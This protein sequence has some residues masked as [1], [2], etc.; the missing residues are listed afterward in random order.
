M[1]QIDYKLLLHSSLPYGFAIRQEPV[2]CSTTV[3]RDRFLLVCLSVSCAARKLFIFCAVKRR[4]SGYQHIR[5]PGGG[6]GASFPSF[7]NGRGS[8][9]LCIFR[10]C[11]NAYIVGMLQ[12]ILISIDG[13]ICL[14]QWQTD[15]KTSVDNFPVGENLYFYTS[16]VTRKCAN[17]LSTYVWTYGL[18]YIGPRI[19]Y[20][21]IFNLVIMWLTA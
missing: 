10:P 1:I 2:G 14:L 16:F 6:S 12:Q 18:L 15:S 5:H 11:N 21:C 19:L 8:T 17:H 4:F 7:V 20:I 3:G 13:R 9:Y